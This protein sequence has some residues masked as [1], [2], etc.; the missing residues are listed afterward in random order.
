VIGV[1]TKGGQ[2]FDVDFI[3]ANLVYNFR[4]LM[5]RQTQEVLGLWAPIVQ[6][7]DYEMK[8]FYLLNGFLV[9][10]VMFF[11]SCS[12]NIFV[13]PRWEEVKDIVQLKPLKKF[14]LNLKYSLLLLSLS[15]ACS[16]G[17]EFTKIM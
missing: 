13:K 8:F 12:M 6:L 2:G 11:I 7:F 1:T 10:M 5:T 4:Q 17:S 16:V 3:P 14:A 15:G 9:E